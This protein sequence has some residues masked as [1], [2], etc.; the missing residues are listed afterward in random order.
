MK[1][2]IRCI[3][4]TVLNTLLLLPQTAMSNPVSELEPND[5]IYFSQLVLPGLDEFNIEAVLGNVTGPAVSDLDYFKFSGQAGDVVTIDIDGG[6]GGKRSVDT[7]IAIFGPA[8]SY[9]LLRMNDDSSPVD[10][11][12]M[13]RFDSRIVNFVLPHTGTYTVGVS[14]FPR[15][16][17]S[18]GSARDGAPRNGDYSLVISGVSTPVLHIGIEI[19]PGS[20]EVAPLN[21]KSRGKIPVALL[22]SERFNAL[23]VDSSSLMFGRNGSEHSLARC[24]KA[25]EDVNGDGMLDLVCHFHNQHA[26]FAKGDIEGVLKGKLIDGQRIEGR[27]LLKVVPEKAR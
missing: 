5:P 9:P 16:F 27:A 6:I 21:P 13:H 11:G 3:A 12:S 23:D 25:G 26:G 2:A 1:N 15:Y 7:F 22:S 10:E 4:A 17:S 19:K 8:P 20:G 24:G 14:H 18:G